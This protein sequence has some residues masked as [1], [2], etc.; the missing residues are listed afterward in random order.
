MRKK[1][2]CIAMSLFMMLTLLSVPT[3][4]V[5]A[6]NATI[7]VNA[8][9]VK[10]G[11]SVTVTVAVPE[12]ITATIDVSYPSN[13]V[14]FSSCSTTANNTGNAISM[15]L[16]SFS[17][18]TATIT[19]SAKA[20]GTATFTATPITAGS[21]ET[22]EEVTLDGASA[23]VT[24]AN[25]A[26][27]EQPVVLSSNN[28]LGILQLY[29]ATIS[30]AFHGDTTSYTASVGYDV[31]KVTVSAVAADA[32]AK[33]TSVTGGNNLQ[34]GKNTVSIVVQAE[35]GVTKTYTIVVTRAQQPATQPPSTQTPSTQTPSTQTPG[36]QQ[37][38][39]QTPSSSEPADTQTPDSSEPPS[40]QPAEETKFSWNG[41]ELDFVDS[42][43][44]DAI[45]QDFEKSTKM[46]NNKEIPILDFKNGTLTVM[47]LANENGQ[48]S[49]FVYDTNTQDVYPFV[50]LGDKEKY[51][52]V[53]RPND[54]AVPVGYSA[55]TLS[56]EGKGVVDAYRF[57]SQ[58]ASSREENTL[59]LFGSEVFYASE[60]N[61]SEFYLIYCMNNKG[62]K[63]WYQYDST[64]QT[65]QR[66]AALVSSPS[67]TTDPELE[68]EYEALK[69]E[70]E[71]AKKMQ[72]MI[73]IAASAVAVILLIVIIILAIKLGKLNDEEYD[74][75]EYGELLYVEDELDDEEVEIE[76][77]EMPK[78]ENSEEISSKSET[79]S[80][81]EVLLE[82]MISSEVKDILETP[83]E[84]IAKE[85]VKHVVTQIAD[86][87]IYEDDS[88]DDSDLEF[89]E[90]D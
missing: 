59:G 11:E 4:S 3:E 2:V 88:E 13:L 36:T 30:P 43:P 61:P 53:L 32:K 48:K 19:F 28:S 29:E 15:N 39:T 25:Q 65:F 47:Y 73:I 69:D 46:I 45:P 86:E 26:S 33:I 80:E 81:P 40:T 50:S 8:S 58:G 87:D 44:K 77:Y 57:V 85:P 63:G 55:C 23:K 68:D 67:I 16:G 42:I 35:N 12:G 82:Q 7:S 5:Y 27:E 54:A 52:V 34:V 22:A 51:V 76:F 72:F 64:E 70:L 20:A 62:E 60:A 6:A 56:I 71:A 74:E 41:S 79:L 1:L 18:R 10:I 66:Y 90:L 14:S 75:E 17:S 83:K 37:P 38:S 89:I 31:T 49:L 9:S 84:E 78:A 21:E 24:I